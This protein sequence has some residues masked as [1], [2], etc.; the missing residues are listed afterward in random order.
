MRVAVLENDG[1]DRSLLEAHLQRYF[2]DAGDPPRV[3]SFASAESLARGFVPGAY[4]LLVFDCILSEHGP[5]GMDVLRD[6]RRRGE[7]APAVIV[8][9]SPDF[10][11]EGYGAGVVAYLLKPLSYGHLQTE[12]D[13][14]FC[15]RAPRAGRTIS[16]PGS[17]PFDPAECV[18]VQSSGHYVLFRGA[19]DAPE[20]RLRASFSQ[21]RE[22]LAPWPQFFQCTR[23]VLVNLDFVSSLDGGDFV[24]YDGRRV[25]VSRRLLSAARTAMAEQGFSRLRDGQGS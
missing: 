12:L 6:L 2:R 15:T 9:S 5:S 22:E 21:T 19:A 1:A 11:V 14:L 23:G 4:D 16:L 18:I 3:D 20:R 24:L 17:A 8:S 25:P 10:A 7:A 13:R